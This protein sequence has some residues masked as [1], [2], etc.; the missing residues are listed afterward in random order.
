MSETT[1]TGATDAGEPAE[2]PSHYTPAR[3]E[4]EGSDGLVVV[5]VA[6]YVRGDEWTTLWLSI[7]DGVAA[8]KMQLPNERVVRIVPEEDA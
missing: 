2:A 5:T 8:E 4:F 6:H 7:E 1:S 3:V